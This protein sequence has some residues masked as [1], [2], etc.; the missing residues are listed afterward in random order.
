MFFSPS[1]PRRTHITPTPHYLE[2]ERS[3]RSELMLAGGLDVR[4]VDVP[5][6]PLMYGHGMANGCS[7]ADWRDKRKGTGRERSRTRA[8]RGRGKAWEDERH[9]VLATEWISYAWS[10]SFPGMALSSCRCAVWWCREDVEGRL[11]A[12]CLCRV[13]AWLLVVAVPFPVQA[14]CYRAVFVCAQGLRMSSV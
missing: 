5:L 14:P 1:H 6:H 12:S 2:L 4:V 10:P 9:G 8:S 13:V 11:A 7:G 3:A